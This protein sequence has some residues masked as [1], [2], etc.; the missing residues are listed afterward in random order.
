MRDGAVFTTERQ[1][2]GWFEENLVRFGVKRIVLSQEVCPD[3]VL[4]MNDG[5]IVRAEAELFAVNFRY[6]RHD[7]RK[8]DLIVACYASAAA[9]EGVPV[10]AANEFWSEQADEPLAVLP[11]EGPL[12]AI[13]EIIL[14]IAH[15]RGGVDVSAMAANSTSGSLSGDHLMFMRLPT[16]VLQ[17]VP[18]GKITDSIMNVVSPTAKQFLKKHHHVLMGAGLSADACEALSSLRR[19]RPHR[20]PTDRDRRR[21][22]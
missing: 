17:N 10:L 8:V 12:S 15:G 5:R 13:E 4:E 19:R 21:H 3:Y 16:G 22:V 11:A 2:R 9:I 20:V 7:P 6:H 1:F 18:R 14:V